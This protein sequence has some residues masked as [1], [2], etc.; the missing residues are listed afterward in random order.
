MAR[1]NKSRVEE[2]KAEEKDAVADV[3][4]QAV[5]QIEKLWGRPISPGE[6]QSIVK[7]CD[8]F[9]VLGS[10]EPDA[11]VAEGAIKAIDKALGGSEDAS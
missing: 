1:V 11:I 5:R 7:W 3:G 10:Q 9:A 2:S 4:T 6:M 8:D